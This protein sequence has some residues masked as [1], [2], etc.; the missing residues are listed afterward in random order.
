MASKKD[1][2]TVVGEKVVTQ[3]GRLNWPSLLEKNTGGKYPSDKF[4]TTIMIPKAAD[5]SNLKAA[6]MAVAKE[7]F[8]DKVKSLA[9]LAYSPIRDGDEQGGSYKG[10]WTIRAKS[11]FK[12]Q[13]FDK[14]GHPLADDSE[15]YSGQY[16]RL[17]LVPL[18][19]K[20]GGKPGVTFAL[21]NVMILGG[22]E[23]IGG[24]GNGADDFAEY[25]EA[26][27]SANDPGGSINA[28]AEV[29]F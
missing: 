29:D 6:A 5:V 19:Y 24:G 17:S 13:I 12:P 26:V 23:R 22:G 18:S 1:D 15:I 11:T 28:E 7:A 16:A 20:T 9:D 25:A 10:C 21:R 14:A 4:E 27:G 3:K 8:G 2:G